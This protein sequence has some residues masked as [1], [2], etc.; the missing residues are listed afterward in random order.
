M[1]QK[2]RPLTSNCLERSRAL[3]QWIQK[4]GLK[5]LDHLDLS[6]NPIRSD[7]A[8][9]MTPIIIDDN[10]KRLMRLNLSKCY[11]VD[12]G[13]KALVLAC[14]CNA[15]KLLAL[16]PS[17]HW[18]RFKSNSIQGY[19]IMNSWFSQRTAPWNVSVICPKLYIR[20]YEIIT[21]TF[22]VAFII[23]LIKKKYTQLL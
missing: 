16:M 22:S 2:L 5:L 21:I 20:T 12:F 7:W 6:M 1:R 15:C 19:V 9:I 4:G 14:T 10:L 3:R 11:I 13:I 17:K 23:E 8:I 18:F